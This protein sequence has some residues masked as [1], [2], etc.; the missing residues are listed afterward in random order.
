MRS[1]AEVIRSA[2]SGHSEHSSPPP[3][4]CHLVVWHR[5]RISPPEL[6][7]YCRM[8]PSELCRDHNHGP[9]ARSQG[10]RTRYP[11]IW[12]GRSFRI[13]GGRN[14]R[15][16]SLNNRLS[17]SKSRRVDSEIDS[18]TNAWSSGTLRPVALSANVG[19][20]GGHEF[21]LGPGVPWQSR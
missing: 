16:E 9:L 19:L 5:S 7:R 11:Y 17:R 10:L 21:T 1:L 13:N 20:G 6:L 3:A 12:S 15:F 8:E 2:I 18:G 4:C 14:D